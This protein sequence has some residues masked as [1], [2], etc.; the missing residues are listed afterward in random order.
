MTAHLS[1]SAHA[2]FQRLSWS[3]EALSALYAVKF[4][5]KFLTPFVTSALTSKPFTRLT[6]EP[7]AG[8][9]ETH[10]TSET[11]TGIKHV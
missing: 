5:V 10:Y 2:S 7:P 9:L 6:A 8:G 3:R 4:A 1:A 11:Q